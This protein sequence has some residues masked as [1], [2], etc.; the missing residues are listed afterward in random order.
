[1]ALASEVTKPSRGSRRTPTA[2]QLVLGAVAVLLM[3][4][5]VILLSDYYMQIATLVLI[6]TGLMVALNVCI[7]YA[8]LVSVAHGGI[9]GVGSYATG[10]LMANHG[11]NFWYTLPAAALAGALLGLIMGILTLRLQGHYFVIASLGFGL[12]VYLVVLNWSSVTGGA[13]GLGPIAPYDSLFGI[14]FEDS[15]SQYYLI[16][17]FAFVF[18]GLMFAI[19]RSKLGS[20]LEAIRQNQRLASAVGIDPSRTRLVALVVSAAIAGV[21]GSLYSPYV[22]F[23]DPSVSNLDVSF[24]IALALVIAGVGTGLGPLVGAAVYIVLPEM[25]RGVEQYSLIALGVVLLVVV[26]FAPHGLVGTASDLYDR[27]IAA[28]HRPP[29]DPSPPDQESPGDLSRTGAL[30]GGKR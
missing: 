7:G 5:P 23:L 28:G 11:W 27:L 26:R 13:Q 21:A 25:L 15:D 30:S 3:L 2:G 14:T 10:I 19:R 17:A 12:L 1:M 24:K 9:F 20:R 8:G 16:L 4:M 29:P 18:T 6:Y 22:G